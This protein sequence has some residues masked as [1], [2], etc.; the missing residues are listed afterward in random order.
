MTTPIDT[1][2]RQ[3]EDR[4]RTMPVLYFLAAIVII[5]CGL[6]TWAWFALRAHERAGGV[7]RIPGTP[8]AEVTTMGG[9]YH[10]LIGLDTAMDA[11][12]RR[13]EHTLSSW[14]WVDRERGIV[15][16]PIDAAMQALT[17]TVPR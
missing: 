2:V 12:N 14:A 15:R 6:V 10:T 1:S 3:E 16:I 9:L 17:D 5:G 11:M 8:A 7:T 4:V 13:A